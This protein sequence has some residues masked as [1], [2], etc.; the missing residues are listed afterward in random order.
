MYTRKYVPMACAEP[1]FSRSVEQTGLCCPNEL[2]R[3]DTAVRTAAA[4]LASCCDTQGEDHVTEV[5]RFSAG[6]SA[7]EALEIGGGKPVALGSISKRIKASEG[8][9]RGL[10]AR[11]NVLKVSDKQGGETGASRRFIC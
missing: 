4:T 6:R 7:P 3:D 9:L 10:N 1:S 5:Y 2:T 11:I 8:E